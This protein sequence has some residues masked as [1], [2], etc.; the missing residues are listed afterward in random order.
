MILWEPERFTQALR[1]ETTL[2]TADQNMKVPQESLL[3]TRK[4]QLIS[5][6]KLGCVSFITLDFE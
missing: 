6:M 4:Y 3:L 1:S 5:P 2:R